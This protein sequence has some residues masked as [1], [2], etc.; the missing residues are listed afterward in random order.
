MMKLKFAVLIL[1]LAGYSL[2]STAH[3]IT[4]DPVFPV[5]SGQVVITFNADRGD[6]GLKDYTG[7]DVYAHTGVIT[8][9]STG[10]SDWKYVIATWTTNLP[11]AKLTKVSANVYTLTISPSI[12]EFYSVP[13]GEQILKL[14]FVF[15][16]STGSRTGRDI[17]GA[18]IFYNVSEEAAFDILLSQPALYTSLVN[19][20]EEVPVQA[21]ASVADSIILYQNGTQ[22]KKVTE[23]T[24]SHTITATGSGS[25]KLLV[26]AW[27]N[28][29]MKADSVYYFIR[30]PTVT[31]AVPAGLKPGVNITGDNSA[32]FLL[33]A[34]YK[35]SVFVMGDFNSWVHSNEGFMKRS[36]DGNWYWLE[37]TG[38][39]PDVEYGFQYLVDERVDEEA[40]VGNDDDRPL[41][42]PHGLLQD[43][44]R[45]HVQVVGGFIQ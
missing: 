37:V 9:A 32:A 10:P 34:P 11:K 39:D 45:A 12:R 26:K 30:T 42:L 18:D 5:S 38:L 35:G 21:S 19:A 7:D 1:I 44:L 33:Y 41:V 28:N 31:E 29:V 2:A 17:G 13:A 20:G 14:A 23:T 4:A 15:R 6:M 8:S 25:F 24:L 40:V 27:H 3:V 36:P 16:N 22:L 43:I